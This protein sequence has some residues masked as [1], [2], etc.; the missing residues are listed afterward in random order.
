[1]VDSV[2]E[3]NQI[4]Q[5]VKTRIKNIIEHRI[6]YKSFSLIKETE[7]NDHMSILLEDD[8][9]DLQSSLTKDI[10]YQLE[11]YYSIHKKKYLL[12]RWIFTIR[13]QNEA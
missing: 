2:I 4:V 5:F 9:S 8:Y 3:V 6:N 11:I 10:T 7:L 12:E 1:M 13:S